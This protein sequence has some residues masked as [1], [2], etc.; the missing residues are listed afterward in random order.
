[1]NGTTP[2]AKHVSGRRLAAPDVLVHDLELARGL[3]ALQASLTDSHALD[4]PTPHY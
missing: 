2:A 1:M 3:G 4:R